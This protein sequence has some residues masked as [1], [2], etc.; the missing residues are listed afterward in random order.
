[1]ATGLLNRVYQVISC[2]EHQL[3]SQCVLIVTFRLVRI[4]KS[5]LVV[6]H[7]NLHLNA[8]QSYNPAGL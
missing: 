7:F 4:A 3:G 2:D 5:D 8:K 1:M 6:L